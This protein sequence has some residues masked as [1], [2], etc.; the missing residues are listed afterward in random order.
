[1]DYAGV[2]TAGLA[3]DS[4]MVGSGQKCVLQMGLKITGG[5]MAGA[6]RRI[7]ATAMDAPGLWLVLAEIRA[8]PPTAAQRLKERRGVSKAIGLSLN[9]VHRGLLVGLFRG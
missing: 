6:R 4:G 9:E 8:V 7:Y 1:M 5:Q 3:V 2:R